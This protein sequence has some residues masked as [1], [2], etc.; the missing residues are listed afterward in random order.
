MNK[1]NTE[2][3]YQEKFILE[4]RTKMFNFLLLDRYKFEILST[5]KELWDHY[6]CNR[7]SFAY[8][9]LEV[10]FSQED[11]YTQ[12]EQ[13]KLRILNAP[14]DRSALID[15]FL[16]RD[17]DNSNKIVALYHGWQKCH[18]SYYMQTSF[19]HKDYRRKGIYSALVDRILE[20]TKFL[21]FCR[22]LSC[23]SPCNNPVLV[24]KLK[25]GFHIAGMDIDAAFGTNIWLCYFHNIDMKRAFEFRSG[26][27]SFNEKLYSS[28]YG[29]AELLYKE[30]DDAKKRM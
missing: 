2:N 12:S 30:L 14:S 3:E 25:K 28:S 6:E 11:L 18:D 26:H 29:T 1:A 16:I 17:K 27:I 22:V 24:A 10:Y 20:Y 7:E 13:E 9:P 21:G 5:E 19:V 23:H 8:T 4:A 15:S